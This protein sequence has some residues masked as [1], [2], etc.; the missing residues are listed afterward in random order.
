M[1]ALTSMWQHIKARFQHPLHKRL[2][3]IVVICLLAGEMLYLY[4]GQTIFSQF[5]EQKLLLAQSLAGAIDGDIHQEIDSKSWMDHPK[6][7]RY[8]S[9]LHNII[10][11]DSSVAYL[12]SL[13]YHPEKGY[14]TY[15]IDAER[16]ETDTIWMES[17]DLGL[18]VF[19]D[20]AQ[21]AIKHDNKV[22]Y[23]K[24]LLAKGNQ[25]I[26]IEQNNSPAIK[27]DDQIILEVINTDQLKVN[28]GGKRLWVGLENHDIK[29]TAKGVE[30]YFSF[31]QKWE[32]ASLPGVVYVDDEEL[33]EQMKNIIAN[34]QDYIQ[35]E[36]QKTA[37]GNMITAFAIIRD[38]NDTPV[39]LL[40]LDVMDTQLRTQQR[41]IAITFW[42]ILS[43]LPIALG[44]SVWIMK[45]DSL[46]LCHKRKKEKMKM[47]Q[48][49]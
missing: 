28:I 33:I 41:P 36:I 31:S 25:K 1:H 8:Q 15:T 46:S 3:I 42:I 29:A 13:S 44:T 9:I 34:N 18:E 20:G 39:W 16:V 14:F 2:L 38:H 24:V 17:D 6:F 30:W 10:E 35:P 45:I 7:E 5:R 12:Y 47:N 23:D 37:Y 11:K 19:M 40:W 27:V 22:Y 21:L 48:K 49:K 4:I 26:L 43:F 32:S